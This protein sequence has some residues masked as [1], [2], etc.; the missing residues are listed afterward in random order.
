MATSRNTASLLNASHVSYNNIQHE[1]T[2][3]IETY[4]LVGYMKSML[5]ARKYI[6]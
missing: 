1:R 6:T 3:N 2:A 4:V 5:H